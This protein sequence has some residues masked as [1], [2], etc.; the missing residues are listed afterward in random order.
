MLFCKMWNVIWNVRCKVWD[1]RHSSVWDISRSVLTGRDFYWY[2]FFTIVT[3][4]AKPTTIFFHWS[5]ALYAIRRMFFRT[6]AVKSLAFVSG[7]TYVG[8]KY[9]VVMFL[10]YKGDATKMGLM[11]TIC[12][13]YE[14]LNGP[15]TVLGKS[16]NHGMCSIFW[17]TT[18]TF[19]CWPTCI[20]LCC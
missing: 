13:L 10:I 1:T 8:I 7:L 16:L 20:P 15:C 5:T 2:W 4:K 17:V 9:F 18:R 6:F 3:R 19:S 11:F 14:F 12:F